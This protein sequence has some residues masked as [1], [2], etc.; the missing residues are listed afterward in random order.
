MLTNLHYSLGK[1]IF[2]VESTAL[3]RN[4]YFSNNY[5]NTEYK[6]FY[7][8]A[9]SLNLDGTTFE[10]DPSLYTDTEIDEFKGGF[11]YLSEGELSSINTTYKDGVANEGG[12][13]FSTLTNTK[14]INSSFYRN[15]G[16]KKGG[17]MYSL[18]NLDTNITG[19][20]FEDNYSESGHAVLV[21]QSFK[22]TNIIDS[23]FNTSKST[24]FI[25][26]VVS[27]GTI[28]NCT[29]TQSANNKPENMTEEQLSELVGGSALAAEGEAELTLTNS[30]FTNLL[31]AQGIILLTELSRGSVEAEARYTFANNLFENNTAYGPEGGA[32]IYL[33]NPV[34]AAIVNNTFRGNEATNGDGGCVKTTCSNTLC[35]TTLQG[36]IF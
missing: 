27:T 8:I 7:V 21:D 4:A 17:G 6:G 22:H 14:M 24:S 28:D 2:M 11:I 35:I 20:Y 34:N 23:T 3:F 16:R 15:Y 13:I 31:A 12:A 32:G 18:G 29:F 26:L 25:H 30:K 5:G 19:S 33:I 9:A 10:D 36:N 1:T